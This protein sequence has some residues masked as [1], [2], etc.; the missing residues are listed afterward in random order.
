MPTSNSGNVV[1]TAPSSDIL[2]G[3]NAVANDIKIGNAYLE[4]TRNRI[5]FNISRYKCWFPR[6]SDGCY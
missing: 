1:L 6:Y 3:N 2:I 4:P 5:K